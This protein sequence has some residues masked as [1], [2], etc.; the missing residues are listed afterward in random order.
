MKTENAIYIANDVFVESELVVHGLKEAVEV[1]LSSV[2]QTIQNPLAFDAAFVND[3]CRGFYNNFE[4]VDVSFFRGSQ[5]Q[6]FTRIILNFGGIFRYRWG[7]AVLRY[8]TMSIFAN[9]S[10][11]LHKSN[12]NIGYCHPC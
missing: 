7:D 1:Y 11:I 9:S 6:K 5:I 10:Q 2:P 3:T 12:Y 8:I 4:V